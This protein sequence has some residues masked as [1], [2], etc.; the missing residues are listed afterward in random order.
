MDEKTMIYFNPKQQIF[1]RAEASYHDGLSAGLFQNTGN[2]LQP[3]HYISWIMTDTEKRYS[4]REK[5]ALSVRWLKNRFRMSKIQD[6]YRSQ[7][8][9]A[10]VQQTYSKTATMNQK[11]GHRHARC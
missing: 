6:Q 2:G 1:M 3:V 11:V 5:D 4:Q 10:D 8:L 9:I 7:T